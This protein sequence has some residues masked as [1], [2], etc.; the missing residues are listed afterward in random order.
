MVYNTDRYNKYRYVVAAVSNTT[1]FF[2]KTGRLTI[3][4][5]LLLSYIGITGAVAV[6]SKQAAVH[7]TIVLQWVNRGSIVYKGKWT[8]C[9]GDLRLIIHVGTYN[10]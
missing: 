10:M 7:N 4:M 5:I 8:A 6:S 1:H 9:S 2:K 3:Y